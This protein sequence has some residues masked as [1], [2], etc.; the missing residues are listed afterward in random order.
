[1]CSGLLQLAGSYVQRFAVVSLQLFV[2]SGLLQLAQ[3]RR[4]QLAQLRSG[5]LQPV[6]SYVQRFAICS[7]RFVIACV[8]TCSQRFATCSQRVAIQIYVQRFAVASSLLQLAHS[9]VQRFAVASMQLFVA[10][11]SLQLAWMCSGWLQHVYLCSQL[12]CIVSGLLAIASKQLCV[13]VCYSQLQ[14]MYRPVTLAVYVYSSVVSQGVAMCSK[15]AQLHGS[16]M[17]RLLTLRFNSTP[18]VC[19][20][21]WLCVAIYCSYNQACIVVAQRAVSRT[22]HAGKQGSGNSTQLHRQYAQSWLS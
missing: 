14:G 12:I 17:S 11:G 18:F 9:Y 19:F 8:A 5:L 3:L 15:L 4:G 1:M 16:L 22:I 6:C 2:A 10:S 20:T 7:Q 13:A 21:Q